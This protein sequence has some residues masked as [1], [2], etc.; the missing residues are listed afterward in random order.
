ME[1]LVSTCASIY[2]RSSASL[3][4]NSI[5]T[6]LNGGWQMADANMLLTR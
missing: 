1:L 6:G 5:S 4:E 3:R 2:A